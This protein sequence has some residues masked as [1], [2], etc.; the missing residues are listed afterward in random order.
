MENEQKILAR[1]KANQAAAEII[2]KKRIRVCANLIKP[3]S[4]ADI[5][6]SSSMNSSLSSSLSL[7]STPR[8]KVLLKSSHRSYDSLESED[9]ILEADKSLA[10]H[11][12]NLGQGNPH[13]L[14]KDVRKLTSAFE[15][16]SEA[17][18]S[19]LE[20]LDDES[21]SYV[22]ALRKRE[23]YNGLTEDLMEDVE[24]EIW[25]LCKDQQVPLPSKCPQELQKWRVF[26]FD[27]KVEPGFVPPL[28]RNNLDIPSVALG[29]MF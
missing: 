8:N 16:Y 17:N 7:T 9:S 6:P 18:L 13:F 25:T 24:A 27:R 5:S 15:K 4:Q 2:L 28:E 3:E 19:V 23:H 22:R 11:R 12:L 10:N 20:L 29:A 21:N 14:M 1:A 26:N